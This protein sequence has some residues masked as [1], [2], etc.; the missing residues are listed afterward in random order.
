[1]SGV[2]EPYQGDQE[3]FDDGQEWKGAGGGGKKRKG[4]IQSGLPPLKP[5]KENQANEVS[6]RAILMFRNVWKSRRNR[7]VFVVR[8]QVT[9]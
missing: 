2:R 1:M 9:N 3:L 6:K 7:A 4:T 5:L 8:D